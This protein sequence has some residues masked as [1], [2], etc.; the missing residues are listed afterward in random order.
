MFIVMSLIILGFLSCLYVIGIV[1]SFIHISL[2][3]LDLFG[4]VGII[5]YIG[6]LYFYRCGKLI[7]VKVESISSMAIFTSILFYVFFTKKALQG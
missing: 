3:I 1:V 6:I 5:K 2:D 7:L 4:L